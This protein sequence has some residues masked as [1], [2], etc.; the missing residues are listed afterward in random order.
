MI[1]RPTAL[2]VLPL[3]LLAGL[4]ATGCAQPPAISRSQGTEAAQGQTSQ[5]SK[6][7]NLG[8]RTILDAFSIAA[9]PTLAGGGLGYIEICPPGVDKAG[10]LAR[11][12]LAIG[13]DPDDVL[14]FGDMPNDLPMFHWAGFGRVAVANAHASVRELATEITLSNDA[15]GV[16]TYLD[17]MLGS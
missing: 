1:H 2:R 4:V 5:R 9:S 11:V 8:L 10:G 15:D 17:A 7:L 13:V 3:A 14:V 6:V 16:A 12:A